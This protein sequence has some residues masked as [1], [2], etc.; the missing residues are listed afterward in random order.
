VPNRRDR[1][2][3]RP[4]APRW[5]NVALTG[6]VKPQTAASPLSLSSPQFAS[7]T[8]QFAVVG[9]VNRIRIRILKKLLLH[10]MVFVP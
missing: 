4:A 3:L 10:C 8:E 6:M 7:L 2:W 5:L 9:I 1:V